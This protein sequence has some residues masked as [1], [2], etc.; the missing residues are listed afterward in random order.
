MRQLSNSKPIRCMS[1]TFP[2]PDKVE[3][4]PGDV[5][6]ALSVIAVPASLLR[7]EFAHHVAPVVAGGGLEE[8]EAGVEVGA[9]RSKRISMSLLRLI[10]GS[11][12]VDV[13]LF[14]AY[15]GLLL[16]LSSLPKPSTL[17]LRP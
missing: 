11:F 9:E 13:G 7:P 8:S 5:E 10:H 1:V 15:I 12:M 6:P 14:L 2:L 4:D 17:N 3:R 16:L